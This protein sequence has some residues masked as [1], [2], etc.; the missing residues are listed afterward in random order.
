MERKEFRNGIIV[1]V[2]I[3]IVVFVATVAVLSVLIS[4]FLFFPVPLSLSSFFS[5]V[6]FILFSCALFANYF[7]VISL[8]F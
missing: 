1:I 7:K 4:F 6:P 5:L 8:L 2:V 3:V